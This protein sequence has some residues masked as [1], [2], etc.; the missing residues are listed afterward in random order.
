MMLS[1]RGQTL[2]ET[3]V[4]VF[5]MVMGITAALGLA[6]YSL[7][8]STSIRKQIIAMG[9]ARE[10]LEAVKNMRDT[11]WLQG[12]LQNNCHNFV[13][14]TANANCYHDW[15]NNTS[16]GYNFGLS[17]APVNYRL[18]F[19][20]TSSSANGYWTLSPQLGNAWALDTS[21]DMTRGFYVSNAG[22]SGSSGFYRQITITP[23]VSA[24]FNH[25]TA[26]SYDWQRL[27]VQARVWWTD[28]NCQA[29]STWPGANRCS[30]Q[31]QTYLTNWKTY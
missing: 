7:N 16:G 30:I 13:T 2:I 5:I 29:S 21:T 1:Q 11:N 9:L 31:L 27:L 8:A 15:L 17:S 10:G 18:N 24:P 3:M 22:P 28:K 12:Q 25:Q 23:D 26:S 4:A 6:N 14:G 20:G 19:N